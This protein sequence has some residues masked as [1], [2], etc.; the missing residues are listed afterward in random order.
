MKS[1]KDLPSGSQSWAGDVS[2]ELARLDELEAIVRR[3][4]ND[5]G[6]DY[7]NPQRGLNTTGVPSVANP[8]MLK[9]PSLKDLDIRDAQDGDLLTF[10]GKRGVWVARRHDTVVL[11]KEFPQGDPDSYYIPPTE[12]EPPT[13]GGVWS[14]TTAYTN[15]ITDP[16]FE[17]GVGVT[18]WEINADDWQ[19]GATNVAKSIESVGGGRRGSSCMKVT[20]GAT[21][22][23][24]DPAPYS[25]SNW[26]SLTLPEGS[27]YLF[28]PIS[29]KVDPLPAGWVIDAYAHILIVNASGTVISNTSTS[30]TLGPLFD[31]EWH[32]FTIN[33]GGGVAVPP[34]GSKKLLLRFGGNFEGE[35]LNDAAAYVDCFGRSQLSTYFDG[36]SVPLNDLNFSW[37]GTPHNSTSVATVTQQIQVPETITL[38]VPFIVNGRGWTPGVEVYVY[39]NEWSAAEAT[40]TTDSAGN[41][42]ATLTIPANTDPATGPVAGPNRIVAAQIGATGFDPFVEVTLV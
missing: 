31:W 39:E 17:S 13:G 2:G 19:N 42:S 41:F 25:Y 14:S 3:L 16:S 30:Q 1:H 22:N 32:D 9:L 38:G 37:S 4:A 10:D 5:F 33:D 21:S 24:T 28:M 6:L 36:D 20:L 8:V 7:A 34:G 11:P 26:I 29:V 23:G 12:E 15:Y 40:V 35:A 18:S 27:N